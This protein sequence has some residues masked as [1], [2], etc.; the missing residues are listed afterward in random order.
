MRSSRER[1]RTQHGADVDHRA[2][3]A[4][5]QPR[6]NSAGAGREF[7]PQCPGVEDLQ[8]VQSVATG[9]CEL[10]KRARGPPMPYHNI[11]KHA[12]MPWACCS[13]SGTP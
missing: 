12:S 1:R 6:P 4:D 3:W 10:W 5:R 13:R 2:F 7:D 8:R 9:D 11:C